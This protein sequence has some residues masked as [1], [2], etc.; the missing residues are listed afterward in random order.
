M[1]TEFYKIAH[2]LFFSFQ[3]N[4]VEQFSMIFVHLQFYVLVSS[5]VYSFQSREE[6][7][8]YLANLRA[9]VSHCNCILQ[10]QSHTK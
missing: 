8:K 3:L 10:V 5:A 9:M 2:S 7:G 6:N 1:Q 4:Y